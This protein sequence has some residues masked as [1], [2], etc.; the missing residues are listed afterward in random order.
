[1]PKVKKFRR[2]KTPT[3]I[4]MEA[5]ECGAAALAIILAYYKRIVPLE[6]LRVACGVSRD[7]TKASNV[8]KAARS[9]GL[10]AKGFKK[11]LADVQ[12]LAPPFVVFW[13][14]NH[15]LVVEGFDKEKYYL[16]DPATGP[17]V[18]TAEEFD[19]AFTGVVLTF[20]K[21]SDF[22]PGGK[23]PSLLHA[24]TSRLQR[25]WAAVGYIALASLALTIPG[26]IAP[27]FSRIFIDDYLVKGMHK[28]L[29]PLLLAIGVTA[30]LKAVLTW[31]QQNGLLRLETK[32]A[33]S[34][35]GR[36]FW[37]VLRLPMEFFAQRSAGEIVARIE[38][39][40]RVAQ[41][42]SGDLAT[43]A[44]NLLMIVFFAVLMFQYDV[45]LTLIGIV[46]A[47]MNLMALQYVSRKR[48][49]D[50]RR[51]LQDQGKLWGV[52]MGGLLMIET[53][54]STGSE[55]D[56]FARWSGSH[57]KVVNGQQQLGASSQILATIPLMLSGLLSALILGIG[58]Y[59]VMDG[60]LTMGMLVAFQ[61]LMGSFT[62]PA[63]AAED[64]HV[65]E[66]LQ[67]Y[68]ELR[69]VTFGYSRLEP[70]LIKNF[71]LK[72]TP[73]DR[74]AIVGASGSGKS[75]IA[76]LVAGLYA[77][78][79]GEILFDGK[80]RTTIP[81]ET[82]NNSLAVVDQDVFL[83]EGTARDNLTLWDST[84]GERDL[85]QAGKDACIHEDMAARGGGYD[86][87][88]EEWG[89]NFSG[90][91][92]QRME[93]ARALATNPNILLLD[94][95]TAALD[96]RTEQLVDDALRRRGCTSLIVAHRLSTIRDCDE[97][98]VLE[99]GEVVERGS[100]ES[101]IVTGG[102]Y[103]QLVLAT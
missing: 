77:P 49:D 23:K 27:I 36:F 61:S 41:L 32:L 13:N 14:F 38:I 89:R 16:S 82:I 73:G 92:R 70:P 64:A 24:L 69:N 96:P 67:G 42:L 95:A 26:M 86:Y 75:T 18:V 90:G 30:L 83:F 40:D 5:V 43:N 51:L 37:H 45:V 102:P 17:R 65:A 62:E 44:V 94:E 66:R 103:S 54:K 76:K 20:E 87:V 4:Q 12:A 57:T 10:V 29:S 48:V 46:I 97:I 47:A 52:T 53:L 100:H 3:V 81:R 2:V 63:A 91:Q 34:T 60:F 79:E 55:S 56:F 80:P 99:Q 1:M 58:G 88:I 28:W 33:I 22:Q 7:G 78:W 72:L 9:F 25:S 74:V 93:I 98:I 39:N 35:T 68:V 15:F 19:Q 50:N 31:V 71:S 11:E 21:S 6:E 101:M 59:R 8:L 84:I 85:I